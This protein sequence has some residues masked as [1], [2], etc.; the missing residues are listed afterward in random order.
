VICTTP[1]TL[2]RLVDRRIF[3]EELY[4]R[5]NVI[6]MELQPLR[7]RPDVILPLATYAATRAAAAQNKLVPQITSD[8][9]DVLLRYRWPGNVRELERV[10]T[11][12]VGRSQHNAITASDVSVESRSS[13]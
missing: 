10:I 6:S 8:A 2:S 7:E 13:S 9:R 4:H 11:L 1:P 3:S 12:A 5:I